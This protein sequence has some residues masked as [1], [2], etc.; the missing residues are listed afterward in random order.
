MDIKNEVLNDFKESL[1]NIDFSSYNPF[2]KEFMKALNLG[3]MYKLL[4]MIEDDSETKKETYV[5]EVIAHGDKIDDISKELNGAKI[6]L[7]KFMDSHD[8]SYKELA[9]SELNNASILIKKG[10]S[11]LP[12]T[13]DKQKLKMYEEKHDEIMEQLKSM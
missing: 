9:K 2:S 1:K 7:Q 3:L 10:Y 8:E 5:A 4:C 6:Y 13:S 12:G 11:K